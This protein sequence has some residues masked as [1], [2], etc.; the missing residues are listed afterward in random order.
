MIQ[1]FL[2]PNTTDGMQYL[3]FDT[4]FKGKHVISACGVGKVKNRDAQ[5]TDVAEATL[6][7]M[8]DYAKSVD[9]PIEQISVH[10]IG[11]IGKARARITNALETSNDKGIVFFVCRNSDVYD[12][13]VAVLNVQWASGG[14]TQ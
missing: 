5:I 11:T 10:E 6:M 4:T 14:S 3:F 9:A 1:S 13:A 12:A 2:I 7:A 8:I